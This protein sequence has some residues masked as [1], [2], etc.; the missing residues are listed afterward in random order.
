[1]ELDQRLGLLDRVLSDSPQVHPGAEGPQGEVWSTDRSCYELLARECPPGT[2]TLETGLGVSTALFAGWG[3]AHT[4]VVPF[5]DEVERLQ[6]YCVE[7]GIAT[8]QV[9]FEVAPSDEALPRLAREELD[10]VLIDGNH[11]FPAPVIDWYYGATR[12]RDGGLVVFDDLQLPHVSQ[13]VIPFLEADSRWSLVQREWKWAAY[14]RVG[15]WQPGE[16][17]FN[18]RF[19]DESGPTTGSVQSNEATLVREELIESTTTMEQARLAIST[20]VLERDGAVRELEELRDAHRALHEE[21]TSLAH[22]LGA[23]R[24]RLANRLAN[25]VGRLPI[26]RTAVA[27]RPRRR[28]K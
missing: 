17:W 15:T 25:R 19:F 28:R 6:A 2:R 20:A 23:E 11:G 10:V 21:A 27:H 18:Q 1:M 4:C 22:Q 12:L 26:V 24:A 13:T 8:D 5:P 7:R 9:Q 3:C 14:R 16:E